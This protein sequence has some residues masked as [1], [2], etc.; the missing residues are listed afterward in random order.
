MRSA[1][2]DY[3]RPAADIRFETFMGEGRTIVMATVAPAARKPIRAICDDGKWRAFIRVG[4]ENIVA[5]PV[6]LRIWRDDLAVKGP[7]VSMGE[8]EHAVMRTL[9]ADEGMTLQQ[10]VQRSGVARQH[11]VVILARLVR[12]GLAVCQ[13]NDSRFLFSLK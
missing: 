9:D 1:A 12:F 7:V 8:E 6:H 2:S 4:D 13:L 5:S 10:V 3:C 11:V